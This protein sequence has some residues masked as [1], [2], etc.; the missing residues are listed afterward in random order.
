MAITGWGNFRPLPALRPCRLT[1]RS[2]ATLR[3]WSY[4]VAPAE[5]ATARQIRPGRPAPAMG[6]GTG[7]N[8]ISAPVTWATV[9]GECARQHPRKREVMRSLVPPTRAVGRC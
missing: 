1:P 8:S 5:K 7:L 2:G 9:R 6:P 4:G 3:G